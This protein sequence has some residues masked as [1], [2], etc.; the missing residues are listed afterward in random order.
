MIIQMAV[1]V[2]YL[3]AALGAGKGWVV[4]NKEQTAYTA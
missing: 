1:V 4:S 3:E 2:R